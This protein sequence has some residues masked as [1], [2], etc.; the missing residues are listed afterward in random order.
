MESS[1]VHE[2]N[3]DADA[4]A[5]DVSR[6]P[7]TR[8]SNGISCPSK[9]FLES[10]E[11]FYVEKK[12]EKPSEMVSCQDENDYDLKKSISDNLK[13]NGRN[14]PDHTA[15]ETEIVCRN[16]MRYNHANDNYCSLKNIP[17]GNTDTFYHSKER[18]SPFLEALYASDYKRKE[19]S[20]Y[21]SN[22][23]EPRFQYK[24][25][26]CSRIEAALKYEWE[27]TKT[28]SKMTNDLLFDDKYYCGKSLQNHLELERMKELS[29]ARRPGPIGC[30]RNQSTE[31]QKW[32]HW[33]SGLS[34]DQ[35]QRRRLSNREAQRRRRLRLKMMQMSSSQQQNI[36]MEDLMY[37]RN[38]VGKAS[39]LCNSIKPYTLP[40]TKLDSILEKRHKVFLDAQME[41]SKNKTEDAI[42]APSKS[43][44]CRV[45]VTPQRLV[46]VPPMSYMDDTEGGNSNR[47]FHMDDFHTSPGSIASPVETI[48]EFPCTAKQE[49]YSGKLKLIMIANILKVEHYSHF[50]ATIG[51]WSLFRVIYDNHKTFLCI[52]I[53][54]VEFL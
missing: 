11:A 7:E 19:S 35:L 51:Q 28:F 23:P 40:K 37:K 33:K 50:V 34:D 10:S 42:N 41:K 46:V 22:S 47:G 27:N 20:G 53:F 48:R 30:R 31:A 32:R 8:R 6:K 38:K 54:R 18:R 25:D 1:S 15:T 39:D 3:S 44:G 12:C 9:K 26:A 21:F 13:L 17:R 45:K 14:S 5:E 24:T 43:R 36:N 49:M 4:T 29:E 16:S 2:M 52:R